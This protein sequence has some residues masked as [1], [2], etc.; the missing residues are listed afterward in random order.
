MRAFALLV[1]LLIAPHAL[2]AEAAA[3]SVEGLARA[4]DSVVRGRVTK[5]AATLSADRRRVY[6]LVD[7][8]VAARWRGVSA[9]S[10]Q[11]IVPGGVAGGIAQRVDGA[12]SFSQGE[13]VVLFLNRAEAGAYRVN[14]LAQGKFALEGP[15]AAPDLSHTTFIAQRIAAGER[16]AEAMSTAEL[17]RRVRSVP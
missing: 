14:G 12:P 6:S 1:A 13:E 16:R 8:A 7:V 2:G 4:S 11:V 9:R 17:E 3:V 5:I 15:T 10:V